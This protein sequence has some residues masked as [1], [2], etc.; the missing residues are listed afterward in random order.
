MITEKRRIIKEKARELAHIDCHHLNRDTM[1]NDNKRYDLLCVLDSCTRLAW[2]EAMC[3]IKALSA[4][5]ASALT[6]LQNA[7]TFSLKKR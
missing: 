6:R 4:M 3:D 2:A 5:F 1:T 7:T